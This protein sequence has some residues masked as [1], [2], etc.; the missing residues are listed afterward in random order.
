[1]RPVVYLLLF[2]LLVPVQ[3]GLLSPL[4]RFGIRPDSSL[5]ILYAIGLLTSPVEGA[6]AGIGLGLLLDL[7]TASFIGLSA[8]SLGVLGFAAGIL[9][10]RVLELDS[11]SNLVFLA[12]FSLAQS[13][14]TAFFFSATYGD[15]PLWQLFFRRMLPAAI[16]T[17]VIGYF[18]LRF[19]VRRDFLRRILRRE[20]QKER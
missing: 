15:V 16:S 13:L 12:L 19:V 8:F 4:L 11:P 1:M 10:K 7:S 20:L 18:L 2:L 14:G 5:A 3:A 9:G 6:L 17:A